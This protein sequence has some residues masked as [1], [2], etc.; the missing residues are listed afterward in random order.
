MLLLIEDCILSSQELDGSK[1]MG[2]SDVSDLPNN[3][4]LRTCVKTL[5]QVL[6]GRQVHTSFVLKAP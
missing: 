4:L 6:W 5:G 3:N 1:V 2:L